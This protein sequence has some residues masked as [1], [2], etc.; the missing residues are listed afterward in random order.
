M[1]SFVNSEMLTKSAN[2]ERKQEEN[3][4]IKSIEEKLNLYKKTGNIQNLN[5]FL[6]YCFLPVFFRH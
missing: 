6:L 4:I 1:N 2:D 3:N 5:Y